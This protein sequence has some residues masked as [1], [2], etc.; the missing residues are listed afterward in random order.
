MTVQNRKN[1][2]LYDTVIFDLDGTLLDTLEDLK[3]AVNHVLKNHGFPLRSLEEVRSFVGN[4]MYLLMKRSAP[5]DT[6]EEELNKVFQE[7]R[8]YYTSHCKIN[9]R[10][11]EGVIELLQTL[12]A[13]GFQVAIVSNK[14]DAAVKELAKDYFQ[15]LIDVAVG[16]REGIQTK[17]APDMVHEVMKILHTS[18]KTTI[19]VGD[20]EVDKATAENAALSYVLVDWGFRSKAQLQKL[21][22]KKIISRSEELLNCLTI[23]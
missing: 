9:T 13:Q 17:P 8:Q 22:P 2:S 10:P 15:G 4:G 1:S 6:P 5:E 3:D 19:Y 20:S 18:A 23:E 21:N 12:K 11:Y 16:Q 7:Y 14:N